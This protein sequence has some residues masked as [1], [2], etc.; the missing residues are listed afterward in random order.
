MGSNVSLVKRFDLR[1]LG[2]A[3]KTDS[4]FLKCP[5]SATRVGVLKYYKPDGSVFKELRLPEEVFDQDSMNTL[6]GVPV[7]NRHPSKLVDKENAKKFM[8]GFTSDHI[9][10]VDEKYLNTS[11]TITDSKLIEEIEKGGLREVSCGYT[12][13]LDMSPGIYEGEKYD[14]IQRNIKYNH[15]A[16][17]D[18]GRA[19]PMVKLHMDASDAVYNGT[20]LKLDFVREDINSLSEG[21][22]MA[23]MKLGAAEYEV[24]AGVAQAFD[25]ALKDAEKKGYDSAVSE[26]MKKKADKET[27]VK[28]SMDALEAKVDELTATNKKLEGEKMDAK[29]I[30]E[31]VTKRS[32]LVEKAKPIVKAD[33]KFDEMSD[34]EIKKAV[35]TAKYPELKLDEKSPEYI[36]ARFDA[37][38][39]AEPV[40]KSTDDLKKAVTKVDGTRTDGDPETA[41]E[42]RKRNMK[43]DSEAWMKPL[44]KNTAKDEE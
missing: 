22:I 9:E 20:D 5:V 10:K 8:V 40:K 4:G 3:I 13:E 18:R 39:D 11:V 28:K 2:K 16:I 34:L 32:S 33:T 25:S 7:T 17:V 12:C 38:L 1:Q 44:G 31:L 29:Q 19:G 35:I 21:G 30:H 43:N 23:K 6:G 15:L 42:V 14:A 26:E 41:E 27:E 24:D 36:E 37:I